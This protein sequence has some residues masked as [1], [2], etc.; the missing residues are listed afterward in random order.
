[1]PVG[2]RPPLAPARPASSDERSGGG[3]GGV[4]SLLA[5]A[6][7][8]PPATVVAGGVVLSGRIQ[9]QGWLVKRGHAFKNWRRRYFILQGHSL[10]Y[11]TVTGT[12]AAAAAVSSAAFGSAPSGGAALPLWLAGIKPQRSIDLRAYTL[13]AAT[14]PRTPPLIRLVPRPQV[15][16]VA[17]DQ[18]KAPRPPPGGGGG[19]GGGGSGG[20]GGGGAP[21][22][23]APPLFSSSAAA[24]AGQPLPVGPVTAEL[25]VEYLMHADAGAPAEYA[26]W[27]RTIGDTM[28]ALHELAGPG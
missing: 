2:D 6:A 21:S 7:A 4:S 25:A 12:A 19:G 13:E 24:A 14:M 8:R 11:Y 9:M 5:S 15:L 3:G 20:G 26:A 17:G 18:V 28:A 23:T 27:M 22:D 16:M 1:M 10:A